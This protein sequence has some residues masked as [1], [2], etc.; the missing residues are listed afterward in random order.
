[1]AKGKLVLVFFMKKLMSCIKN[2]NV[3]IINIGKTAVSEF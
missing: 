1:M 2:K 3:C